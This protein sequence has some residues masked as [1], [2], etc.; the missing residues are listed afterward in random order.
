MKKILALLLLLFAL[1]AHAATWT[2]NFEDAAPHHV[3]QAIGTVSGNGFTLAF[4]PAWL[5]AVDEDACSPPNGC[6]IPLNQG[7]L[8]PWGDFANEPSGTCAGYTPFATTD[9]SIRIYFTPPIRTLSFRYSGNYDW[10]PPETSCSGLGSLPAIVEALKPGNYYPQVLV[11]YLTEAGSVGCT[12]DP[13][14]FQCAWRLASYTFSEPV[15]SV[16]IGAN[17]PGYSPFY[18]DDITVGDGGCAH[19][20]CEMERATRAPGETPTKRTTWGA[21]KVIYR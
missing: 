12:G 21:V 6:S 16:R 20:P 9:E 19:P 11:A 13:D 15:G 17:W 2:Y 4:G 8:G 1:P 7:E 5:R 3:A 18:V 10:C 14:G